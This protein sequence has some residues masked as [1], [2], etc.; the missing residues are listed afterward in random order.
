MTSVHIP[1][2]NRA[3]RGRGF[4]IFVV[5]FGAIAALVA[6]KWVAPVPT[7]FDP[8][9]SFT[10]ASARAGAEHKSVLV[11]VT[12]DYCLQCQIFK[13]SALADPR[14]IEWVGNNAQTAY[15]KWGAQSKELEGL[16]VTGFPA[17]ILIPTAGVPRT[18]VGLMSADELLSFLQSSQP[19]PAPSN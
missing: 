11:V 18:H 2:Y 1:A 14:V 8:T 16:G 15:V 4:L 7:M 19:G 17:T 5:A 9:V 13:R 10:Q 12:A 6:W 3:G